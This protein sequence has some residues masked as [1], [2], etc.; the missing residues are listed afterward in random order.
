MDDNNVVMIRPVELALG[1]PHVDT[2]SG[3]PPS[4]SGHEFLFADMWS[5]AADA[6]ARDPALAL[7]PLRALRDRRFVRPHPGANGWP[8]AAVPTLF[9]ALDASRSCAPAS[10]TLAG[11]LW[12]AAA[13]LLAAWSR[14]HA[15]RASHSSTRNANAGIGGTAGTAAAADA[16][17][18]RVVD[19]VAR[20]VFVAR[21][22]DRGRDA[23]DEDDG[24]CDAA[25]PETPPATENETDAP[26]FLRF[27]V[28]GGPLGAAPAL[29]LACVAASPAATR[30][31]RARALASALRAL[32]SVAPHRAF[33]APADARALA[34]TLAYACAAAAELHRGDAGG[35]AAFADGMA[36]TFFPLWRSDGAR[37]DAPGPVG[38]SETSGAAA[39]AASA[40][41]Q[42]AGLLCVRATHA[43]AGRSFPRIAASL[44]RRARDATRPVAVPVSGG[45]QEARVSPG[46]AGAAFVA[47]GVLLACRRPLI[48]E[49][50]EDAAFAPDVEAL[51]AAE[52]HAA[53]AV[54]AAA[55][56][57]ASLAA[58]DALADAV[59]A[60][61][62]PERGGGARSDGAATT[63]ANGVVSDPSVRSA[64]AALAAGALS[65]TRCVAERAFDA[66]A[67][68]FVSAFR[69]N[70]SEPPLGA[71]AATR[72]ARARKETCFVAVV[73]AAFRFAS[74]PLAA[75]RTCGG[76]AGGA[77]VDA[78]SASAAIASA[79]GSPLAVRA[80]ALIDLAWARARRAPSNDAES[81]S[82]FRAEAFF[83]ARAV[84]R[85]A[86]ETY[87]GYVSFLAATSARWRGALDAAATR[88]A[89]ATARLAV[90]AACD[91]LTAIALD[92][93]GDDRRFGVPLLVAACDALARVEFARGG[94]AFEEPAPDAS[95][96]YALTLTRL[97]AAL[98]A[99]S[100]TGAAFR[101][102]FA[103]DLVPE[104]PAPTIS[105]PRNLDVAAPLDARANVFLR[106]TPYFA[107]GAFGDA[108]G[109][110]LRTR[111]LPLAAH[112]V[113]HPS[114]TRARAA[115]VAH[116]A[117]FRA[118]PAETVPDLFPPYVARSLER[119][120]AAHEGSGASETDDRAS[121]AEE[122]FAAT[123]LV[124]AECGGGT[125][126]ARAAVAAAS[127]ALVERAARLDA[128]ARAAA[129]A[130]S[131]ADVTRDDARNAKARTLRRL[132]FSLLP[133]VDHALVPDVQ[134]AA[135]EAVLGC[136]RIARPARASATNEGGGAGASPRLAAYA[137]LT[138]SV[139]AIADVARKGAV[140]R[141]ALRLRA[142]M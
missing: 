48:G 74:A 109:S 36:R 30:E 89:F 33:A 79:R 25:A 5:A 54:E 135:E 99:D 133:L 47:A 86:R 13:G 31:T 49:G 120:Y 51:R 110:A 64:W 77:P 127:R 61:W 63:R 140:T 130:R 29:C 58:D 22:A 115:H 125:A 142:R 3:P 68:A 50:S 10:P 2:R 85:F 123:V 24:P 116:A 55:R 52:A 42:R 66:D 78:T 132:V 37:V 69:L 9:A 139:M 8:D 44:A 91:H 39:S 43:T 60:S 100:P 138:R 76:V 19:V 53:E 4:A 131:E 16:T 67:R 106:L 114:P 6:L 70:L 7:A 81:A 73:S 35:E 71:S 84:S 124:V 112:Y 101:E 108:S 98:G 14:W 1:E 141:W 34:A 122:A 46:H 65:A 20:D 87:E 113:C 107:S 126:D 18:S 72:A 118:A 104:A 45:A 136:D 38:R 82:S 90:I 15:P 103:L 105:S 94:L 95:T 57:S 93:R 56:A 134:R 121:L 59:A 137:D 75:L 27:H 11:E 32:A 12:G 128:A 129:A 26:S 117:S 80:H 96:R 23:L 111:A 40:A 17:L 92:G 102:R 41:A 62:C 28:P 83:L 97:A 21:P 88:P 119:L